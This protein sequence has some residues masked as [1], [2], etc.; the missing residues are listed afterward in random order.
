MRVACD[1][2]SDMGWLWLMSSHNHR[3]AKQPYKRDHILQK[4][5]MILRGLLTVPSLHPPANWLVKL[6]EKKKPGWSRCR[7]WKATS[8]GHWGRSIPYRGSYSCCVWSS[9]LHCVVLFRVLQYVTSAYCGSYV[10]CMWCSVLHWFS[11]LQCVTSTYCKSYAC[12]AWY[13][14]LQ[15]VCRLLQCVTSVYRGSHLCCVCE[16]CC[17][18]LHKR[19]VKAIKCIYL[20][21]GMYARVC[22]YLC[23]HFV[24][25]CTC[26]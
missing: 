3:F 25:I 7:T 14:V 13:S 8:Q 26:I 6:L 4:R 17:T 18:V 1:V 15:C 19:R 2:I 9:V 24:Y 23:K 22:C 20:H 10:C 5:H 11:V 16:L 12:C 21:I